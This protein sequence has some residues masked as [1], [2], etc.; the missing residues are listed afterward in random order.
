MR[1]L[2]FYLSSIGHYKINRPNYVYILFR[3]RSK[4]LQRH[5][6]WSSSITSNYLTTYAEGLVVDTWDKAIDSYLVCRVNKVTWYVLSTTFNEKEEYTVPRFVRVRKV[7]IMHGNCMTC[8][9]GRV[10]SMLLPCLHI[11]S[12]FQDLGISIEPGNIH[13]R[14][15]TTHAFSGNLMDVI[16]GD[17]ESIRSY[18]RDHI[19]DN[20]CRLVGIPLIDAQMRFIIFSIQSV[21]LDSPN[22]QI[23]EAIINFNLKH[24]PLLKGST[25]ILNLL[26]H[27]HDG[28]QGFSLQLDDADNSM[29]SVHDDIPS[30]DKENN[31]IVEGEKFVGESETIIYKSYGNLSLTQ[32]K[33][34]TQSE[35]FDYITARGMLYPL[36]EEFIRHEPNLEDITWFEEQIELYKIKKIAEKNDKSQDTSVYLSQHNEK[37]K[38]P[39]HRHPR[40]H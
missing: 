13:Y 40:E 11:C 25:E 10:Q 23:M 26:H 32:S 19:Y 6:L 12:V 28:N 16:G 33:T 38:V 2:F 27:I 39:R 8:T 9:C 21:P 34:E 7:S 31:H 1:T 29:L 20:D 4:M 3:E 15:W 36:V 37:R 5:K 22:R 30:E 24:G 14:W 18:Y 35:R 17:L